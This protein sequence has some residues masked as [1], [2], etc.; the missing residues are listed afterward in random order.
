MNL[1]RNVGKTDRIVRLAAGGLLV[2]AG[3]VMPSTLVS[4]IGLV[5]L[6][7]GAVGTC[8]AYMPL[9]INTNKDETKG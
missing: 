8:P 4:I 6:A 2:F 1:I 5:V 7:T 3:I 9:N